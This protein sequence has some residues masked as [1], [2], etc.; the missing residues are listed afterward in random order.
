M[1]ACKI[2]KQTPGQLWLNAARH[3]ISAVYAFSSSELASTLRLFGAL[4][5]TGVA[6]GWQLLSNMA[7]RVA[8]RAVGLDVGSK[9]IGVAVSDEM[10]FAAHPKTVLARAGTDADVAATLAVISLYSAVAVVVGM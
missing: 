10:G 2:H 1:V 7:T 8:M 6:A 4:L 3:V 9:T 5:A